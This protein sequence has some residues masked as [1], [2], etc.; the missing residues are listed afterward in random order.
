MGKAQN[1]VSPNCEQIFTA[2]TDEPKCR[3]EP[4]A[5]ELIKSRVVWIGLLPVPW[6]VG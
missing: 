1:I 4:I 6:T 5:S 2:E 3:R